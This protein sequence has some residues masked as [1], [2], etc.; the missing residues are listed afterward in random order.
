[1]REEIFGLE[2]TFKFTTKVLAAYAHSEVNSVV[3]GK[4]SSVELYLLNYWV[5]E[6]SLRDLIDRVSNASLTDEKY[7]LVLLKWLM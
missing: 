3:L 2:D 5:R 1:M 4:D 6:L 7:F